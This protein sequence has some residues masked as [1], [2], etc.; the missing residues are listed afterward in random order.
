MKAVTDFAAAFD[1]LFIMARIDRELT[2][3][4]FQVPASTFQ[5]PGDYV[6]PVEIRATARTGQN[7][8][9]R[10]WIRA[11]FRLGAML[12]VNRIGLKLDD[13]NGLIQRLPNDPIYDAGNFHEH[14]FG[15]PE[16]A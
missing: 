10:R 16:K 13:G 9:G 3:L 12:H 7:G 8:D 4:L 2:V 5:Y 1:R 11:R 15:E 14:E 6:V